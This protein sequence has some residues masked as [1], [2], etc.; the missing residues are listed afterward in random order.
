MPNKK[1]DPFIAIADPTRREI[2]HMLSQNEMRLNDIAG[3]FEQS[4]P[5]ISKHIKILEECGMVQIVPT[6]RERYCHLDASA[7]K[8]ISEWIK[9][10]EKF[11]DTKLDRL[12]D[13][14]KKNQAKNKK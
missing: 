3:Q 13:Y 5:A 2:I 9:F 6:G 10:Y 11:W 8:Q 1:R 12:G 14:L 4:R 7:L